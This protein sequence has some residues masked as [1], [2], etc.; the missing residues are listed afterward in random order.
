MVNVC[1]NSIT[2]ISLDIASQ[3][4]AL[5]TLLS[6]YIIQTSVSGKKLHELVG[7]YSSDIINPVVISRVPR[8]SFQFV[9]IALN[10]AIEFTLHLTR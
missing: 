8:E 4:L 5:R 3:S 6:S 1:T 2:P 9:S 7:I 10:S